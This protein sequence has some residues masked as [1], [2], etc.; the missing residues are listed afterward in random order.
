MNQHSN[1]ELFDCATE[2]WAMAQ[3]PPGGIVEDSIERIY[4]M[5]KE[6]VDNAKFKITV[7]DLNTKG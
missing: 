7:P 4:L 1:E 6:V 5:L 3:T 2:I